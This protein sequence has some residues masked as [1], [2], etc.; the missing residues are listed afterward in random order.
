M[1][2][3]AST[4]PYLIRAIYEWCAENGLTPYLAAAVDDKTQVPGEFVHNGEIVLNIGLAATRN[5]TLGNDWITFSARF[6]GVPRE[7]AVPVQAVVAIYARENGQG[8]TFPREERPEVLGGEGGEKTPP[9][10]K[11]GRGRLKVVK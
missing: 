3:S 6:G 11:G 10:G 1:S 7:I 5:L 9:P 4:K 2:G 8:L